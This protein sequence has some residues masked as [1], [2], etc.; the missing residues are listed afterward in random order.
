MSLK[1]TFLEAIILAGGYG[2]RLQNVLKDRPKPMALING[3]PFLEYLILFLRTQGIKKIILAVGYMKEEIIKYFAD[4]MKFDVYIDYSE[5]ETPL[6]TGGAV[7]KAT[8]KLTSNTFFCLNGDSFAR[9]N[10]LDLYE[11]HNKKGSLASLALV[12]VNNNTRYGSVEVD[13]FER[14]TSFKEK[15]SKGMGLINSGVYIFEKQIFDLI[16]TD[17]FSLEY[18]LLPKLVNLGL[19]GKKINGFFIDIGT[20]EDY[21]A[22]KSDPSKFLSSLQNKECI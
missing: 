6:G 5:E 20:P 15:S 12:N 10:L 7:K 13:N 11:F 4:G 18:D 2:T 21:L 9:V 16:K 8:S 3:R 1:Q 22:L 17:A 19:Y 14:I